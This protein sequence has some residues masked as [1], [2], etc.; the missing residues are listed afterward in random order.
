MIELPNKVT[1]I[2]PDLLFVKAADIRG[3]LDRVTTVLSGVLILRL[4]IKTAEDAAAVLYEDALK[5]VYAQGYD[6]IKK[7]RGYEEK[8]LL[9]RSYIAQDII[10][11]KLFWKKTLSDVDDV[12][13]LIKL[14]MR[15][16]K[17]GLDTILTQVALLKVS[18]RFKNITLS[19]EQYAQIEALREQAILPSVEGEQTF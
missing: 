10:D 7:A 17:G 19:E 2:T 12:A 18:A 16:F 8:E 1:D 6:N 14:K 5:T 4:Q 13:E 11:N 15:S 9:A 3:H